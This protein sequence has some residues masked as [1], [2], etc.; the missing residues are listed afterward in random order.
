MQREESCTHWINGVMYFLLTFTHF[1]RQKVYTYSLIST[2][3]RHAHPIPLITAPSKPQPS[4][5]AARTTTVSPTS[6]NP[7]LTPHSRPP[8][9]HARLHRLGGSSTSSYCALIPPRTVPQC[10]PKL[11]RARTSLARST[12]SSGQQCT[13]LSTFLGEYSPM[14]RRARSKG[15]RIVPMVRNAGQCGLRVASVLDGS[16]AGTLR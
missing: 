3:P 6:H 1:H 11:Y 14:G 13:E 10:I 4:S 16:R 9:S 7:A 5:S 2:T 8:S 12:A 15:P